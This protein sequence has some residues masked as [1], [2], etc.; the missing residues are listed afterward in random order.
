MY[1]NDF[2]DFKGFKNFM[3]FK[4]FKDFKDFKMQVIVHINFGNITY[5]RNIVLVFFSL[6]VAIN[7]KRYYFL[8]SIIL[9]ESQWDI[10]LWK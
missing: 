3:N 6:I 4:N 5:N 10:G 2:K 9:L 7:Y 8:Q 1:F